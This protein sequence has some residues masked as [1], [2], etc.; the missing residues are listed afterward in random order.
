MRTTKLAMFS[1]SA[2]LTAKPSSALRRAR[3]VRQAAACARPGASG[4]RPCSAP[5]VVCPAREVRLWPPS[6][7]QACEKCAPT[8]VFAS[9]LPERAPESAHAAPQLPR[10]R[11]QPMASQD[12][13]GTQGGRTALAAPPWTR[14]ALRRHPRGRPPPAPRRRLR[15]A[16]RRGQGPRPA[17]RPRRAPAWRPARR[18]RRPPPAAARWARDRAGRRAWAADMKFHSVGRAVVKTMS[19]ATTSPPGRSGVGA[20]WAQPQAP[21]HR[22]RACARRPRPAPPASRAC[23]SRGPGA[24]RAGRRAAERACA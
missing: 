20:P 23:F 13:R 3:R 5:R 21:A 4:A 12:C 19:S 8:A 16:A 2:A 11:R 17:R 22:A 1:A 9:C 10:A 15:P 18:R 24:A 7:L 14:R 6:P